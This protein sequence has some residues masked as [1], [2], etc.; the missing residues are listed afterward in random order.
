MVPCSWIE[1]I[2]TQEPEP[3]ANEAILEY[4]DRQGGS[5]RVGPYLVTASLHRGR[6]CVCVFK[7]SDFL[8]YK[9]FNR[10]DDVGAWLSKKVT[11]SAGE[12]DNEK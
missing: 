11:Q 6:A 5:I 7:D 2:F 9:W 12:D 4:R 1:R 3:P 10:G 8:S